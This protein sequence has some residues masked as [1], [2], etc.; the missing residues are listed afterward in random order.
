[1]KPYGVAATFCVIRMK[2]STEKGKNMQNTQSGRSMLEMLGVLSIIGVL[3][4]GGLSGYSKMTTQYKINTSMQQINIISSKLSAIGSQTR[5]YNGLDNATAIKFGV[6]PS[7]TIPNSGDNLRNPFDG[8]ITIYGSNLLNGGNDNQAYVI[9]YSGIPEEACI[10]LAS[11]N[12]NNSKS[13][14]LLGIG[15]GSGAASNIYQGCPGT[16]SVACPEGS[17]TALP[18]DISKARAACSC[19]DN[20][21]LVV[22]FF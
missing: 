12:W 4:I 21:T 6:L 20:C 15:V 8:A 19:Q 9:Q 2:K 16:A 22:K 5:S 1:M 18:M 7:E 13:S 17:V 11:N 3:S 10:S 14:S